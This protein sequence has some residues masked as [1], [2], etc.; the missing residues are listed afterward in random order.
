MKNTVKILITSCIML[1]C[2]ENVSAQWRFGIEYNHTMMTEFYYNGDGVFVYEEFNPTA[3]MN[4]FITAEYILPRK[5]TPNWIALSIRSQF[6]GGAFFKNTN[7]LGYHFET[8]EDHLSDEYIESSNPAGLMIPINL[9]AKLLLNNNIRFFINGGIPNMISLSQE[10]P[11]HSIGYEF[12]CGFEFGFFR[13]GYKNIN[14]NKSFISKN[15]G[16]K[17]NNMHT[18]TGAIIFNGNR[19]LKKKSSLKVY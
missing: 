12:G 4:G 1:V 8:G 5:W 9:E 16:N 13:I 11:I 18:L 17:Y 15:R 19:F 2:V 7:F 14:L 10:N 6:G 3:G